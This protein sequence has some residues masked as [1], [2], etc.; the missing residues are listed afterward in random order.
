MVDEVVMG[1]LEPDDFGDL[2]LCCPQCHEVI[3]IPFPFRREN[4]WY[5]CH[6]CRQKV[7]IDF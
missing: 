3:R 5:P 7:L 6:C 2:I 4:E 1:V